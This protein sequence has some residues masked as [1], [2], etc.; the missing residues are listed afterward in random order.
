M[1]N[2]FS[3]LMVRYIVLTPRYR[4]RTLAFKTTEN[5]SLSCVYQEVRT[6][7]KFHKQ[8]NGI[9]KID[10]LYIYFKV[11]NWPNLHIFMRYQSVLN[12]QA[13]NF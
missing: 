9:V 4:S 8:G 6:L 7:P 11:I 10:T 1:I 3:T 12:Y 5:L 2:E 13:K